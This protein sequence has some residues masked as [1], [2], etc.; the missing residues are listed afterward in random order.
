MSASKIFVG[1]ALPGPGVPFKTPSYDYTLLIGC[2]GQL[3]PVGENTTIDAE[4]PR[5]GY[6][7]LQIALSDW[8]TDWLVFTFEQAASF[9]TYCLIRARWNGCPIGSA[10]CPVFMLTDLSGALERSPAWTSG[11][12]Q[13]VSWA[14]VEVDCPI[15]QSR[16]SPALETP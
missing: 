12:F 11:D 4:L 10:H 15:G 6:F 2:R 8:G 3:K 7:T 5:S 16:E 14:D 9:G 13:F 1:R